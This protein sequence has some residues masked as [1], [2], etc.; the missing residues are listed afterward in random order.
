[1]GVLHCQPRNA[2]K[3]RQQTRNYCAAGG[4]LHFTLKYK[5]MFCIPGELKRHQEFKY[6][7]WTLREIT[8][9]LYTTEGEH[10]EGQE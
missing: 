7:G 5:R 4:F 3:L 6:F 10:Q 8:N 2:L 1:M 9:I